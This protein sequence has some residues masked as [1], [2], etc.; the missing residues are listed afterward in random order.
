MS[1]MSYCDCGQS[2]ALWQRA[3]FPL[4][5]VMD[6]RTVAR[7]ENVYEHVDDIDLFPGGMAEKPVVGGIVGEWREEASIFEPQVNLMITSK[8]NPIKESFH[9]YLHEWLLMIQ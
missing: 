4:E 3:H 8:H 6:R 9:E 7:L 1:M 5:D 2:E